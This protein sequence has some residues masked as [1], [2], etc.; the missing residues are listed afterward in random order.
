MRRG[1]AVRPARRRRSG[2]GSRQT[3]ASET[4]DGMPRESGNRRPATPSHARG[5]REGEV[6]GIADGKLAEQQPADAH[7]HV[8]RHDHDD[9]AARLQHAP[10]LGQQP[11]RLARVLEDGDQQHRGKRLVRQTATGSHRRT[12][13]AGTCPTHGRRASSTRPSVPGSPRCRRTSSPRR[14]RSRGCPARAVRRHARALPRG[15]SGRSSR[16]H[17]RSG[18]R[19]PRRPATYSWSARSLSSRGLAGA[20]SLLAARNRCSRRTPASNGDRR[21]RTPNRSRIVRSM[22]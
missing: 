8:V 11:P 12:A 21:T 22:E 2:K 7:R 13:A 14:S 16:R 15:T 5:R 9:A 1:Q 19:G 3:A 6:I 18:N 20:I 4:A 10:R 17:R